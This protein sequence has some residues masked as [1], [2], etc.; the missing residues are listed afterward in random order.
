MGRRRV[1]F[2]LQLAFTLG[3]CAFLIVPVG[4]SM[5]AGLTVNYL[6]GIERVVE[7]SRIRGYV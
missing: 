3:V 1:L 2:G 5:L 6:V 4:L 7:A